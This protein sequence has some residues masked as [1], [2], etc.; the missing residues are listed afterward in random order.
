[1]D[2]CVTEAQSLLMKVNSLN[3]RREA[4]IGEIAG[5]AGSGTVL[6][7]EIIRGAGE[8][9]RS[10]LEAIMREIQIILRKHRSINQVNEKLLKARLNV[11]REL[12]E[13]MEKASGSIG[14]APG[15][16]KTV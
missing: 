13:A 12:R 8:P 5:T 1:M 7:P 10:R 4:C 11:I 16:D 15:L 3:Q 6:L 2:R 14:G 9:H